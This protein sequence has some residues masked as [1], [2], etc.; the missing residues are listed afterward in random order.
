MY[1]KLNIIDNILI[2]LVVVLSIVG[3][4]FSKE[5]SHFEDI[6]L[7]ACIA[8]CLVSSIIISIIKRKYKK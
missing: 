1:K 5:F 8:F 2:G 4:F 3:I 6:L 7:T